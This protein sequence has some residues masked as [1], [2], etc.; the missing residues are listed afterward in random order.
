MKIHVD[1]PWGGVLHIEKKPMDFELK[2][3]LGA[4][5]FMIFLV[6]SAG[7]VMR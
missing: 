6:I 7:L 2:L 1:L 5:I 3:G 4:A